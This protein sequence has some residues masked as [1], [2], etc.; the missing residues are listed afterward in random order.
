MYKRRLGKDLSLKAEYFFLICC[1][2]ISTLIKLENDP[3]HFPA[4]EPLA[5]ARNVLV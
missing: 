2:L 5:G 4:D 3:I 1:N